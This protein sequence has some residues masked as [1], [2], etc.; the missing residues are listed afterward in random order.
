M[1]RGGR[2][3]REQDGRK[4]TNAAAAVEEAVHELILDA[5]RV[6]RR[7]RAAAKHT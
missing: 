1:S 7:A 2:K 6:E 5:P 3:I 4:P